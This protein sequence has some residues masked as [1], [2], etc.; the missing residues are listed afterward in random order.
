MRQSFPNQQS[1]GCLRSSKNS[2]IA[3]GR[4]LGEYGGDFGCWCKSGTAPG[5]ATYVITS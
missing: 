3:T 2:E 4:F 5:Y 1:T